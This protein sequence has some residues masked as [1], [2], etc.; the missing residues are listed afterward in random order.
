M[1]FF[2]PCFAHKNWLALAGQFFGGF[3]AVLIAAPSA[4]FWFL[5]RVFGATVFV[6]LLAYYVIKLMAGSRGRQFRRGAGN[7]QLIDS[8]GV[9]L[10]ATVHLIKAG[11]KY[12][13]ISVTKERV[14]MLAE[15]EKIELAENSGTGFDSAQVPFGSLLAKLIKPKDQD[16]YGGQDGQ[17]G[18]NQGGN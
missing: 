13:V 1:G 18:Q 8:M 6:A 14:D 9:G 3:G 5:A 17:S 11:E 16:G 12:L 2:P 15:V 10:G 4:Q 7:L